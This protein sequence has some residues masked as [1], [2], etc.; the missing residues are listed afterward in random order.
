MIIS[1][2]KEDI[3]VCEGISKTKPS[4]VVL[5]GKPK[6]YWKLR[7]RDYPEGYYLNNNYREKYLGKSI[8]GV[9]ETISD[10]WLFCST[11]LDEGKIRLGICYIS[12]LTKFGKFEVFP[13]ISIEESWKKYW[14]WY[15]S[16]ETNIGNSECYSYRVYRR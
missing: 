13:A 2:K 1:I 10:E 6:N 3:L 4:L 12:I 11:I 15:D 5:P 14:D 8:E 7:F 16:K 9:E